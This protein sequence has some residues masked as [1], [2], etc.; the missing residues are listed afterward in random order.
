M[1]LLSRLSDKN[2]LVLIKEYQ[3]YPLT[4]QKIIDE[5]SNL[6]SWSELKFST[7]NYLVY[8]LGLQNHEPLTIKEI[9]KNENITDQENYIP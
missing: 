1:N 2:Y 3:F 8:K 6:N 7:V 4:I 5:L 9:F